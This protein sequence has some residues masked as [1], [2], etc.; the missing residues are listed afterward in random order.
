MNNTPAD[1]GQFDVSRRDFV[2]N[3]SFTAAM[4]AMG[5]VPLFAQEKQDAGSNFDANAILTKIP[6][7]VIGCGVWGR[8]IL[9]HLGRLGRAEVVAICD[10]YPAFL[11]RAKTLA[12]KAEAI[13]DYK[14]ILA[15]KDIKAVIIATP[16]HLH[17]DIAVEAIAAGKHVYCEAPMATTI[18]DAKTIAKAARDNPQCYFQPGLLMR[19]D[20][21]RKFLW[22][23][24]R[25]GAAGAPIKAR[26]QW[27]KKTSWRRSSPNEERMKVINWRLEKD[28]SLGLVGELGIQQIDLINWLWNRRPTAV[29]GFGNIALWQDG[30]TV[31]DTVQ[32]IFEYSDG[33]LFNYEATLANSYDAEYET[34]FGV[35]AAIM[36]RGNKAWMFKEVDSPLLGWE[37]YARKEVFFNET[38]IA[39]VADATKSTRQTKPGEPDPIPE[40]PIYTALDSFLQNTELFGNAVVDYAET[41]DV[42]DKKAL[43]EYLAGIGTTKQLAPTFKEGYESNVVAI[44]AAEAVAKRQRITIAKD[45]FEI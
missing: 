18:D 42:K 17:K 29:T 5:G 45:L 34:L 41:F 15:N 12:P 32:A 3:S 25:S 1:N 16:S 39:L 28:I 26:A 23:F 6:V 10:N 21:H 14:R 13:A 43:T 19:A 22:D 30:R 37:V 44:K 38:G 36:M 11:N 35:D 40:P 27:H 20:K 31:D 7:A 8:E 33:A 4:L 24:V 9:G 2:R